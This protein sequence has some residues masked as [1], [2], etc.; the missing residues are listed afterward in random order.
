MVVIGKRVAVAVALQDDMSL[1]GV[2]EVMTDW[3][4]HMVTRNGFSLFGATE[5]QA[6]AMRAAGLEVVGTLDELSAERMSSWTARPS[7]SL[8][9]T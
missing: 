2:S 1:V 3:R 5:N 8:R 7:A 9:R 4:V 6:G